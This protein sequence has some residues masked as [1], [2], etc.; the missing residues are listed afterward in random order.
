MSAYVQ[1]G[2]PSRIGDWLRDRTKWCG[3]VHGLAGPVVIVVFFELAQRQQKM[4][5]VPD[6]GAVEQFVA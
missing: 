6:Q 2:G 4:A 3:L 1:A 5:L